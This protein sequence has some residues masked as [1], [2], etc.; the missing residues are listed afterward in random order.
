M[1]SLIHG[2]TTLKLTLNAHLKLT[3]TSSQTRSTS[4]NIS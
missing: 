3:E 1:T 2:V 4:S